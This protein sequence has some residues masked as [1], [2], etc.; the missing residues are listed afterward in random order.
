M[1]EAQERL[2]RLMAVKVLDP[3]AG[4][5][6]PAKLEAF[7]RNN[8]NLLDDFPQIRTDLESAQGTEKLLRRMIDVHKQGRTIADRRAAFGRILE[9][10]DPSLAIAQ[11]VSSSKPVTSL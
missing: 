7:L 3:Q 8:Q 1:T 6:D 4:R 11:A 5:V 2:S 10:D 9:V